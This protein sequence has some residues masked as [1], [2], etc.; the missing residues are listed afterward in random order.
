MYDTGAALVLTLFPQ[1]VPFKT[2]HL[3]LITSKF[4][5]I[6][7]SRFK[8]VNAVLKMKY[9]RQPKMLFV[10]VNII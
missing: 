5:L 2:T 10:P 1:L 8:T 3:L 6:I 7:V 4:G 9:L